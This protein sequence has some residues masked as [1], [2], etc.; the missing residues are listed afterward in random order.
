MD[1][2]SQ[3]SKKMFVY[4]GVMSQMQPFPSFSEPTLFSVSSTMASLPVHHPLEDG[5][6]AP[7]HVPERGIRGGGW[8]EVEPYVTG[9]RDRMSHTCLL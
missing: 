6:P 5:V 4:Q 9:P 3:Y 1:F 7:F 8:G 2:V